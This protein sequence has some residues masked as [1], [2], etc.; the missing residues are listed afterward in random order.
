MAERIKADLEREL[1]MTFSMGLAASKVVAKIASK[2]DKPS[3]LIVIPGRQLHEFLSTVPIQDVWGIG[4]KTTHYLRQFDISSALDFARCDE[5]WVMTQLTKPHQDIW[6]ELRGEAVIPLATEAKQSYQ[7]ISKTKTFTPPSSDRTVILAQLSK[8]TENACIK[9]R[10][11]NLIAKRVYVLLRTQDFRHQGLEITL[12]Q[13]SAFPNAI[14]TL[15][16]QHLDQIYS[17]QE[18]Y[19]LTGVVLSGL[20]DD[21]VRQ[22][23]LFTDPL[24]V[25]RSA[26]LYATVDALSKKYGKHT[27][28]LGSSLPAITTANHQGQRAEQAQ[29]KRSLFKGEG[30]RQRLGLPLLGNVK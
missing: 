18:R 29:R 23:E 30:Q 12:T 11:Y 25:E 20:H 4:R 26:K 24:A 19:R 28:F 22:Y 16:D 2:W 9:A 15:I 17:T 6:R 5:H 27:V 10:R 1:G 7:S 21:R 13:P 14:I 8:N 3:G